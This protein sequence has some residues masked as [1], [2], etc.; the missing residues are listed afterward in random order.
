MV[1]AFDGWRQQNPVPHIQSFGDVLE[2]LSPGINDKIT[3][4]FA[5]K[6]RR[7]ERRR[8]RLMKALEDYDQIDSF[9]DMLREAYEQQMEEDSLELKRREEK[10]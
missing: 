10:E 2:K 8:K 7:K 3:H 5:F 4:P 9:G 6:Q 1:K